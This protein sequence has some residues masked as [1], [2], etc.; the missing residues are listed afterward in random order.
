MD[1]SFAFH[2]GRKR[3]FNLLDEWM[4]FWYGTSSVVM[5]VLCG[6]TIFWFIIPRMR[7]EGILRGNY[8]YFVHE[9]LVQVPAACIT[10]TVEISST[11]V[12]HD[13]LQTQGDEPPTLNTSHEDD[14]TA[15]ATMKSY[16]G[17]TSVRKFP[18]G[19]IQ[20]FDCKVLCWTSDK[21][22]ESNSRHH[23]AMCE[24]WVKTNCFRRTVIFP[25]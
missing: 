15:R 9:A 7:L 17:C 24:T 3:F 25:A 21:L 8:G 10:L 6:E 1:H 11:F 2:P 13:D 23:T 14:V 4:I 19:Y 16:H 12:I 20:T 5:S 22:R 18:A